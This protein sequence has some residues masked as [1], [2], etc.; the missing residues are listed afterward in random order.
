MAIHG[1]FIPNRF[2]PLYLQ[3]EMW[4]QAGKRELS[5][6]LANRLLKKK[7]KV[8][9]PELSYYLERARYIISNF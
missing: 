2:K 4:E 3:M 7:I 9:S 8:L 5:I 6:E 1:I